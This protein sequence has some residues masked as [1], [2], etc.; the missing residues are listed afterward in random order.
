MR[1]VSLLASLA[2]LPVGCGSDD[3]SPPVGQAGGARLL[4]EEAAVGKVVV[5][6]SESTLT[7]TVVTDS[8]W[9]LEQVR[10]AVGTELR[11]IPQTRHGEPIP[12]KFP[13]RKKPAHEAT[14]V[15][16]RL[17]LIV[18]P[19]TVL[20]FAVHAEVRKKLDKD[21]K[22]DD[23]DD[24]DKNCD[25]ETAWG[26]G[27][28]FPKKNGSMY[29]NYTVQRNL[30]PNLAG[31]YRTHTQEEWGGD[32]ATDKAAGFMVQNFPATFPLGV[33]IG[34]S[35]G[36]TAQFTSAA[37]VGAFLPQAGSAGS[38][39]RNWVNPTAMGNSLACNTL[40]LAITVGFDTNIKNFAPGTQPLREL[41][42][43][44]PKH[45]CFGLTVGDVLA[46]ANRVLSG[47]ADAEFTADVLDDCVLK[48]NQTFQG[49]TIDLGFVGLP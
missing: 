37:A 10:L 44:N 35:G 24:E 12:G 2:L 4:T 45:P 22:K 23:K 40:A 25:R 20:F 6:N 41:V 38:L 27:T 36:F 15:S 47:E 34:D 11:H 16:W 8:G 17:P 3:D 19:D 26:E 9:T 14:E 29:F 39:G 42:V 5:V 21:E 32:P 43:A 28:A 31:M 49:G 7:V 13:L 33:T 48:I 46:R 30:P 1:L 18:E